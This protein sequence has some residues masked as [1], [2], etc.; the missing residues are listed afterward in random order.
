[1]MYKTYFKPILI[2]G[3]ETW[4]MAKKK[5]SRVQGTGMKFLRSMLGKTRTDRK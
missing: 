2:Y 3:A 4:A 5:S 1:M